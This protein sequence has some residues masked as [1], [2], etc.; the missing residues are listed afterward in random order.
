MKKLCPKWCC[1]RKA[2]DETKLKMSLS[3]KG[4]KQKNNVAGWNK[5]ISWS[6]EVRQKMSL[7]QKG[8]KKP[9]ITGEKNGQWKGG[10]TPINKLIRHSFEYKEWIKIIFNRDNYTCQKCNKKS[11]NLKAH[12][13]ESF[14]NNPNLRT[15]IDN[16]ITFC[17]DCHD[18]FHHIFGKGNNT[19]KQLNKFIKKY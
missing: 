19:K 7:A 3:H 10:V 2:S 12:H 1:G 4:K 8:K 16:G 18:N 6:E 9:Y 14:D 11:N 15:N 13:I 17:K 5:G